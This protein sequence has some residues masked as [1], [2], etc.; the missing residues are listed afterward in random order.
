MIVKG[1]LIHVGAVE[2]V[3]QNQVDK[4][5][6]AVETD[7]QYPQQ[8][9]IDLM[10]DKVNLVRDNDN[11]RAVEVSVNLRGRE[12]NGKYYVN[13]SGWKVELQDSAPG[14]NVDDNPF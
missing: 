7:E 9:G 1:K 10:K 4:R 5:V 12:Y 3:G 8:I 13:L 11:G 6:I 14:E 2:Q